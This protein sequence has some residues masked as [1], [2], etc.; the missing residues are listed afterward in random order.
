MK[1]I[2]ILIDSLESNERIEKCLRDFLKDNFWNY[3]SIKLTIEDEQ[4]N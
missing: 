4:T 3:D 2:K 1:K